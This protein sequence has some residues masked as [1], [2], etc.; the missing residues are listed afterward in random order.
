MIS[1][2]VQFRKKSFITDILTLNV[3]KYTY[4]GQ[5][6]FLF[7]SLQNSPVQITTDSNELDM[8]III[9]IEREERERKTFRKRSVFL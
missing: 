2:G 6:I 3:K 9:T 5:F 1:L 7:C 4:C 8:I